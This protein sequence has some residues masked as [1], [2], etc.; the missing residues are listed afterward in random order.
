M[1]PSLSASKHCSEK[2]TASQ[3]TN[4][5]Y[6]HTPPGMAETSGKRGEPSENP[7]RTNLLFRGGLASPACF[8]PS[9]PHPVSSTS[10]F[11][12]TGQ[13][14]PSLLPVCNQQAKSKSPSPRPPNQ[15]REERGVRHRN[16]SFIVLYIRRNSP[17]CWLKV[18]HTEYRI[19]KRGKG[20]GRNLLRSKVAN[21]KMVKDFLTQEAFLQIP[22]KTGSWCA[23]R[24][25]L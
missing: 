7:R 16:S 5:P 21:K 1:N 13:S 9:E 11:C 24:E 14:Y 3:H 19:K 2:M 6:L 15:S 4:L 10:P 22:C 20:K 25:P 8:L 18:Q 23:L 12:F 17:V